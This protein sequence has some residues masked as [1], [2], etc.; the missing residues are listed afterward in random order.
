MIVE[1]VGLNIKRYIM[2]EIK[3]KLTQNEIRSVSLMLET[4]HINQ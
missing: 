1:V 2:H 3:S 4:G